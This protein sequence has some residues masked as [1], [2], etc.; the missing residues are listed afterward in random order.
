M[1]QLSRQ[2]SQ[3]KV[4]GESRRVN[5]QAATLKD[6]IQNPPT[7]QVSNHPLLINETE[8]VGSRY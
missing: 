1:D 5:K 3:R 7:H 4:P 8:S 6:G 2:L